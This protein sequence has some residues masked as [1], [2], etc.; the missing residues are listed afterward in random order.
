MFKKKEPIKISEMLFIAEPPIKKPFLR[1]REML[2]DA[3][4]YDTYDDDDTRQVLLNRL[5]D[6]I[7]E[8]N[9][10]QMFDV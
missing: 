3:I 9:K 7:E 1:M 2:N 4:K 5:K 8:V 6:Y 10:S